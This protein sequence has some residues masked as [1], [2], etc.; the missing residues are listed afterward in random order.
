MDLQLYG[1]SGAGL[2][3][4]LVE[5]LK[6]SVGLPPRYAGLVAVALGLLL[7][8]LLKWDSPAVGSWLQVLLMGVLSGLSA[9]GL[10]SGTRAASATRS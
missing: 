7:A 6:R 10:Y 1:V 2:I 5:L 3:V 8:A 9:A 4:G